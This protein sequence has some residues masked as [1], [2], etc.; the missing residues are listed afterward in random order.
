[1]NAP[2]DPNK[3]RAARSAL[4]AILLRYC[5]R[6]R[7]GPVFRTTWVMNEDCP[8]C[9]L[10]FDRGEP[11]YFTGAMYVSYALAIPLL[12]L[13]TLIE[14]LMLRTWSLFQLVALAVLL[15]VPLVPWIWQY[16]RVL[17]IA[18]DRYFDPGDERAEPPRSAP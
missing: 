10:D 2:A 15:S 1:M 13:L 9:G 12:S 6:C 11:G 16:S 18:F 3:V 5:P 14:Y 8:V 17:W 7:R 4:A